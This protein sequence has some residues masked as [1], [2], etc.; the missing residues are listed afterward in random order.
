MELEKSRPQLNCFANVYFFF[1][2][3]GTRNIS[4]ITHL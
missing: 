3:K 2:R 1:T 4:L